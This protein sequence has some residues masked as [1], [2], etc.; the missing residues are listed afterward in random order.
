ML[1]HLKT[2][3]I[4][5]EILW[6]FSQDPSNELLGVLAEPAQARA[7]LDCMV[8]VL[9]SSVLLCREGKMI[10]SL[11]I[12]IDMQLFI[13]TVFLTFQHQVNPPKPHTPPAASP[14]SFCVLH[15]CQTLLYSQALLLSPGSWQE[16]F[17]SPTESESIGP[18]KAPSN[19][20]QEFPYQRS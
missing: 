10:N 5:F 18:R 9:S 6:P 11:S 16:Q 2:Q 8:M 13:E 3:L 15:Q 7:T 19:L 4:H 14:C 17:C 12:W 20:H 1:Q